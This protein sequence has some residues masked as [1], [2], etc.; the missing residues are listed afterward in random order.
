M[1]ESQSNYILFDITVR[2]SSGPL[3]VYP[4]VNSKAMGLVE[5]RVS[6]PGHPWLS[7]IYIYIYY[8]IQTLFFLGYTD[9]ERFLHIHQNGSI[10]S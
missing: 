3:E 8:S 7:N 6:W 5:V 4:I 9:N 10:M 2:V 1:Q